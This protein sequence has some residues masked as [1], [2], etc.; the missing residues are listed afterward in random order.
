MVPSIIPKIQICH[1]HGM[2]SVLDLSVNTWIEWKVG[3]LLAIRVL[4]WAL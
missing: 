4:G 3:F 2:D 1:G